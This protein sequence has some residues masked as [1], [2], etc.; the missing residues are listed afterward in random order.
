[1]TEVGVAPFFNFLF[2]FK[3]F[4]FFKSRLLTGA[5]DS[6]ISL[7]GLM[8]GPPSDRDDGGMTAEV[9]GGTIF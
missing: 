1:M 7:S 8:V 6:N 3:F 5:M 9:A 4:K 2:F